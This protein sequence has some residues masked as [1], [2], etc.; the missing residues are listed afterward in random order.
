[1]SQKPVIEKVENINTNT[2]FIGLQTLHWRDQEGKQRKWENA[3]RTTRS[4]G[5][6]DAVSIAAVLK[7]KNST[8][9]SD[10]ILV[11]QY[12]PPVDSNVIEF[13]AGLIDKGE[14]AVQAAIREL[15]EETGYQGDSIRVIDESPVVANDPGM[16]NANMKSVTIV[17]D[18][19]DE[20]APPPLQELD[21]GEHI[22]RHLVPL[23]D[24]HKKILEFSAE[25]KI[26]D[27][28]LSH[29]GIGLD[30]AQNASTLF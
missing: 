6:V 24:L 26:V 15:R 28:R 30:L 7:Y 10:V 19:I 27:A 13:P 5:G 12:R 16:S 20:N 14:S 18:D 21:D 4:E 29:L 22:V 3:F 1:M 11:E 23:K 8:K 25:G 17:V 2:K 9:P